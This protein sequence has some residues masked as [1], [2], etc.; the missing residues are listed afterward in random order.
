MQQNDSL[1]DGYDQVGEEGRDGRGP[2]DGVVPEESSA[3][4][5]AD[6]FSAAVSRL[7][8]LRPC[9]SCRQVGWP[10]RNIKTLTRRVC[11]QVPAT[12]ITFSNWPTTDMGKTFSDQFPDP[13]RTAHVANSFVAM[14]ACV[15]WCARLTWPCGIVRGIS[16]KPTHLL[17]SGCARIL[18]TPCYAPCYAPGR[19]I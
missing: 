17:P 15:L 9:S 14:S 7:Y 6:V 8:E 12:V 13:V 2:G 10:H 5:G 3:D 18:I 4:T 11:G 19:W 16:L 1:A